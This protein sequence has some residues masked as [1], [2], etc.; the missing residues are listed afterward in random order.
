MIKDEVLLIVLTVIAAVICVPLA[1]LTGGLLLQLG[2][3]TPGIYVWGLL[4]PHPEPGFLVGLGSLLQTEIVVDSICCFIVLMAVAFVV[5]RAVKR[6][7]RS[8]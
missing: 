3:P 6:R 1:V 7:K 5:D 8:A 4:H 2:L